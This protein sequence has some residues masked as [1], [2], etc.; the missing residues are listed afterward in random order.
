[1]TTGPVR[2]A[3]LVAAGSGSRA[4]GPVPKQYAS[5]G[6]RP[7]IAR[8]FD[9]LAADPSVATIV[10]VIGAGQEAMAQAALGDRPAKIVCGGATRRA[11]V[12][13]GL[14][15]LDGLDGGATV[16]IHDA[17]R[18]FLPRATL[19]RLW[20]ALDTAEGAVPVMP[21]VD[22]LV[23]AGAD[24]GAV[25]PRDGVA[26]VQTPQVF[27]LATIRDAHAGWTGEEPTDD[28]QMVRAAGRRVVTVPGDARLEKLTLSADLE[29]AGARMARTSRTGM[30]FDV[31]AFRE[32]DHVWIGGV[33]IP[34]SHGLEGHSD[35]DVALHALTD[36][37]LGT[38][39]AGD[40]GMH[41]PPSD[42]QWKG[43]SSDRFLVHARDLIVARGGRI[44]HV[45]VTIICEAP[46]IRPHVDA[47]QA[48]IAGLLGIGADRTSVKATTTE[49]LGFTG[50]REGIAAQAV[51]TIS[52]WE[53]A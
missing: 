43:A 1:M 40:I 20:T 25:I 28:A 3:V 44:D 31:H 6:G 30:G 42:P 17:A 27:R 7:V 29:A 51:A 23:A 12:A 36:A 18:P 24:L 46:K 10:V 50:R 53:D 9:A 5:L 39:A 4:G 34:H 8:A 16:A 32:G 11:S 26:R 2:A 22:T 41:F 52:L 45:D 48:R 14:A 15:A 37:L 33:R 21:A 49:R 38:I 35:A 19:D 47:I 13:A